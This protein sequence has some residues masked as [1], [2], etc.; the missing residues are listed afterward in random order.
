MNISLL[1]TSCSNHWHTNLMSLFKFLSFMY[2][3]QVVIGCNSFYG[4][5]YTFS[6]IMRLV[7]FIK[8]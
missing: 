7:L 3:I 5:F 1:Y 2:N 6:T 8:V 4:K